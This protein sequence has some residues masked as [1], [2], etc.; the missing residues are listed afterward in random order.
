MHFAPGIWAAANSVSERTSTI[1]GFSP[2]EDNSESSRALMVAVNRLF[3]S[4][5]KSP[6]R[7]KRIRPQAIFLAHALI[8]PKAT[9]ESASG[10]PSS[11]RRLTDGRLFAR[12]SMSCD[13]KA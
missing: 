6:A 8:L 3:L 4:F 2:E 9:G 11:A 12:W 1:S 7:N 13:Q 10:V 5:R